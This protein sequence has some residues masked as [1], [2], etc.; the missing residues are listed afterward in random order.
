M[1]KFVVTGTPR[2]GTTF[3]C[4]RIAK[5]DNV[6]MNDYSHYEPFVWGSK[7]LD[8]AKY[9][10]NLEKNHP[11]KIVGFKAF[12]GDSFFLQDHMKSYD[13]IVIIR[14]DVGKV[15]LSQLI[16]GKKGADKN[17]SSKNRK[18]IES[19]WFNPRSLEF[20]AKT[21]L[22]WYYYGE[23][24]PAKVKLYFEDIL[25]GK[26]YPELDEYFENKIDLNTNYLEADLSVYHPNYA[27]L[28]KFLRDTAISLGPENF[29]DYVRE[30]LHI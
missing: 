26:A 2:S 29:P 7:I 18:G 13:A 17:F 12:F 16:K 28:I 21:L 24:I 3:L 27:P 11:D 20:N 23:L 9:L 25:D 10:H 8:E 22:K 14:R 4:D 5:L 19:V 1:K 6:Y 30:N 15:F